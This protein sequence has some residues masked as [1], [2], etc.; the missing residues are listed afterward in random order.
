V[1]AH[2]VFLV[3]Q[4][5]VFQPA[6]LERVEELRFALHHSVRVREGKIVRHHRSH[7]GGVSRERGRPTVL[8]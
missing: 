3:S 2:L 4:R 7:H 8:V 1:D 6:G 5:F